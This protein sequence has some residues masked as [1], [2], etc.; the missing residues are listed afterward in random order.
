ME[1]YDLAGGGLPGR[2]A[3]SEA[4]RASA[5]VAIR[6]GPASK[7]VTFAGLL[8][9]PFEHAAESPTKNSA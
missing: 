6:L 1:A 3:T 2:A 5:S 9:A 4:Q 7:G 8:L